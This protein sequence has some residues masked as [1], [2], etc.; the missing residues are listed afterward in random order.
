MRNRKRSN[1]VPVEVVK[2]I[3]AVLLD[4]CNDDRLVAPV[5]HKLLKAAKQ[6]DLVAVESPRSMVKVPKQVIR[7]I[8]NC[9]LFL[10]EFKDELQAIV[11]AL[12]GKMKK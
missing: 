11:Y 3:R 5:K 7:L 1:V 12:I 4:A 10:V 2:Q 8:L 6:L 9:M